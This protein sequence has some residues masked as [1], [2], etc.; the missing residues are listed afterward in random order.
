MQAV[1]YVVNSFRT[2]TEHLSPNKLWGNLRLTY[3]NKVSATYRRPSQLSVDR[4]VPT[5]T[6]YPAK[7][8]KKFTDN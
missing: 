4:K 2:I 6:S 3:G 7:K 8:T 5:Y 1:V